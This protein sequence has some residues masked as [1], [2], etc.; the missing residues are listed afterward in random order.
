MNI[1]SQGLVLGKILNLVQ[2]QP[3]GHHDLPVL[4]QVNS[5]REKYMNSI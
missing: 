2:V 5:F 1:L 3:K 4:Y